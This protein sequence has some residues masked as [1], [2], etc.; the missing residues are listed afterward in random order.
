MN[1]SVINV[2]TNT[3]CDSVY[4]TKK[5]QQNARNAV[6][7]IRNGYSQDL[8]PGYREIIPVPAANLAE[9]PAGKAVSPTKTS[10]VLSALRIKAS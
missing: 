4:S 2:G 1:T 5:T 9:A 7:P 6:I 8:L 10:G 3:S